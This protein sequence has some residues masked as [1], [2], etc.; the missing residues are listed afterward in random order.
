MLEQAEPTGQ[1]AYNVS[2]DLETLSETLTIDVDISI[3]LS[4]TLAVVQI[5]FKTCRAQ[6]WKKKAKESED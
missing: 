5:L 3:G 1:S 2:N 4:I 6:S